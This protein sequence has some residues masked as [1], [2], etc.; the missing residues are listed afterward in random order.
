MIQQDAPHSIRSCNR[1]S[2]SPQRVFTMECVPGA[3]DASPGRILTV[4]D[5]GSVWAGVQAVT[6]PARPSDIQGANAELEYDKTAVMA[7]GWINP[8]ASCRACSVCP[9][10]RAH[11]AKKCHAPGRSIGV[12]ATID[13]GSP[14]MFFIPTTAPVDSAQS[15]KAHG[16][17]PSERGDNIL[18]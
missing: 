1:R 10:S 9:G 11:T 8:A 6:R 18:F 12:A 15:Y 4:A 14:A 5:A 3:G 16:G 13:T 2:S 17:T 7:S